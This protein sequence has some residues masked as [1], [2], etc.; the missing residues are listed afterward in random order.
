M[1]FFVDFL[2][3]GL[4]DYKIL[5]NI[6]SDTIITLSIL[7]SKFFFSNCMITTTTTITIITINFGKHLENNE[8]LLESY[9]ISQYIF[10]ALLFDIENSSLLQV[11]IFHL[12]KKRNG[13]VGTLYS[14]LHFK[15]LLQL[16]HIRKSGSTTSTT[17]TSN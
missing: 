8:V 2:N 17:T 11:E 12:I 16:I 9:T 15:S 10:I 7:L 6:G 5:N 1:I 3:R 4:K 13:T 14:K